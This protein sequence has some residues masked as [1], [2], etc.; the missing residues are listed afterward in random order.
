MEQMTEADGGTRPGTPALDTAQKKALALHDF[1]GA[2]VTEFVYTD[3][4]NGVR[5]A[6][7]ATAFPSGLAVAASF[8]LTLAI[9]FGS[10]MARETLAAGRNAMLG[11]GLDIARVPWSGRLAESLGEDPFL[12]GEIGGLIAA[13][14]QVG[15][16]LS[17]PKHFVANNFEILRTGA[18]SAERRSPAIDVRISPRALREIYGEPFRRALLKYGVAGVLSSYNRLNGEY[19]S[20]SREALDILR[21]EWGWRGVIVPDFI[22]AVRDD[23]RALHAGLDLPALGGFAGRTPEMVDQ[24]PEELLDGIA[25]HVQHAI[26]TVGLQE[27][28]PSSLPLD[29][30]ESQDL[31]QRILEDGAVLLANDGVLPLDAASLGSLALPGIED[32]SHLL[33]MG[34]SAS[35]TLTPERIESLESV[36]KREFSRTEIVVAP[37]T[38]GD[39]PLFTLRGKV[40]AVVRD[41][42]TGHEVNLELSEF[43]LADPPEG[44][45]EEWSA[46]LSCRFTPTE[47]GAHRIA[48]TFAGDAKLLVN[49]T[50]VSAG[51]REASPMIQ[52]PEYPLQTV[53]DLETRQPVELRVE[54]NSGSAIRVP[55]LGIRPGIRLGLLG[56]EDAF[57]EA[58]EAARAAEV[59]VVVVGRVS[60]EAM[61]TESLRLPGDQERLIG[62]VAAVNA[63]TVVVTCG[64]GPV[65]MPWASQVAAI[66]HVWNP[67]E[68]F[69]PALA[70][71]LS[72]AVEPGGRLP[73]TFPASEDATPVSSQERYPGV[74]AVVH[75]DE[76]LL[77]GYRW[78]EASLTEP[79][80]PFGHGLGYTSFEVTSFTAT[81]NDDG[82]R[83]DVEVRN[84]R[85]RAGKAVP[86]VYVDAPSAAGQPRSLRAFSAAV[87]PAGETHRFLMAITRDDLA[88][89]SES[90]L[91]RVVHP[92]EYVLHVGLSSR[93]LRGSARIGI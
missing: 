65:V 83:L 54:F 39:V 75:Y 19:V 51:Y 31:A 44:V 5:D 78:Y 22:F 68:R 4:P 48:L 49:G 67:G 80:F 38:L 63:K 41:D 3:G 9:S 34:G 21:D 33:V 77:V 28:P 76:E 85:E 71:I 53:L 7:G 1:A 64:S 72:G 14:I 55:P 10:A 81:A 36:L 50:E 91:E 93:D 29:D 17:I 13:A 42:L 56:P 88:A 35:V 47:T 87:V 60:G 66:L 37:G 79:A 26:T 16:V 12:T 15:G 23:A 90:G 43:V 45:G 20:E 62:A 61:D 92:G 2:G 82:V 30:A 57:R 6:A 70:R 52:G 11:P 73:L 32:P 8:D 46:V 84:L 40:A 69:G 86:Q 18:G 58:V 74:D 27:A 89:Y 25:A 24:A 59:A